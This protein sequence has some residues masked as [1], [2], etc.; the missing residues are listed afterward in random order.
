[1]KGSVDF[2][3]VNL[4]RRDGCK[5]EHLQALSLSGLMKVTGRCRNLL[6]VV[7][8]C[9]LLAVHVHS[10]PEACSKCSG[11]K[12]DQC[13]ECRPGWTLHNNS[14]VGTIFRASC[15]FVSTMGV[16]KTSHLSLKLIKLKDKGQ[17]FF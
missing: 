11:L 3:D 12:Y 17:F 5:E 13:E 16:V 6:V 2:S 10:C 8:L 14:C 7:C 4:N 1:M 15:M 9:S